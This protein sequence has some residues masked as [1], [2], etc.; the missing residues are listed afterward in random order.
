M[1]KIFSILVII[2]AGF[3]GSNLL[4]KSLNEGHSLLIAGD[5][6]VCNSQIF[7]NNLKY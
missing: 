6:S 2:V 4:T 3:L 5:T 7:G 1:F